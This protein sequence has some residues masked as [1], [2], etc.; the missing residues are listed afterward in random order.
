MREAVMFKGSREGLQLII[1]QAAD[2]TFILSHLKIKLDEAAKFFAAGATV[3][4]PAALSFLTDQQRSELSCLLASYGLRWTE[5]EVE[6]SQ[7]SNDCEG[8]A[9]ALPELIAADAEKQ[10]TETLIIPRT[11]RGGQKISY[12][13]SV[14]IDGHVNP[15][16]EVIAGGNIVVM[17]TC[18]GLAHAGANGS[19]T[20][21][22]TAQR[23]IAGQ[24]RI[25]GMIARAPDHIIA[26]DYV[27]TARIVDDMIVIEPAGIGGEVN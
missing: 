26:S 27:E 4:V 18:R 20:A 11:L 3:R 9:L 22:I 7:E 19:I 13:G 23:L 2:F 6:Y 16:A 17:G 25:A 15:G 5:C 21:T 14:I 10:Q 1:N 24:L 8:G 12:G